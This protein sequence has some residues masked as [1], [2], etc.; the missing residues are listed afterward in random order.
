MDVYRN[1]ILLLRAHVPRVR[2][3][4][5][6]SRLVLRRSVARVLYKPVVWEGRR[7]LVMRMY[8]GIVGY[9][10]RMGVCILSL[11]RSLELSGAKLHLTGVTLGLRSIE[12]SY[13][14]K[15]IAPRIAMSSKCF[16]LGG[17]V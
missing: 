4:R 15:I 12:D 1:N 13:S 17:I 6:K 11:C 10:V 9:E 16:T 8:T 14:S 3:R 7:R 2:W 5:C